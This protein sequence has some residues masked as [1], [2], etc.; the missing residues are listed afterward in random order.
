MSG[1]LVGSVSLGG[2]LLLKTFVKV[3]LGGVPMSVAKPPMLQA[4]AMP[5]MTAFEKLAIFLR[6]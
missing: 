2:K 1:A 6:P 5:I 4:K 3:M